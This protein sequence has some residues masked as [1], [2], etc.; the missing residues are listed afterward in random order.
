MDTIQP[1][2]PIPPQ[3]QLPAHHVSVTMKVLLLIFGVIL[4]AFL[5]YCVWTVNKTPE[6]ADSGSNV[7]AKKTSTTVST[8][9]WKTYT[10]ASYGWSVKYPPTWTAAQSA[11]LSAD[12]SALDKDMNIIFS[13]A[14]KTM[15][16]IGD[17]AITKNGD[18][19][20]SEYAADFVTPKDKSTISGGESFTIGGYPGYKEFVTITDPASSG[21]W[22]FVKGPKNFYRFITTETTASSNMSTLLT[23]FKY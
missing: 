23:T 10:N 6:V 8:T 16:T 15:L 11:A 12:D 13:E 5:G 14:G 3:N 20:V 22:Y 4:I 18:T 17:E 7:V 19:T 9:D 2:N 1:T 21:L